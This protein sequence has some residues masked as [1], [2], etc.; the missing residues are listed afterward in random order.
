VVERRPCRVG[1]GTVDADY[2]HAREGI[3][4]CPH[5]VSRWSGIDQNQ[6]L[7]LVLKEEPVDVKETVPGYWLR[8]R[9]FAGQ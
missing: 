8:E 5:S 3:G 7:R 2:A 1:A 4:R 6:I 9:R